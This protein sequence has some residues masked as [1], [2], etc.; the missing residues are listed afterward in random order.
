VSDYG[1]DDRAIGVPSRAE[2]KNFSSN[3]WVQTRSGFTQPPDQWV[4]EFLSPGVKRGRVVT[5]NTDRQ[6]V[7]WS[8]MSRSYTSFP[9]SV[10]MVSCE[11]ALYFYIQCVLSLWDII[12][13]FVKYF[14]LNNIIKIIINREHKRKQRA[15]YLLVCVPQ[16]CLK[17]QIQFTVSTALLCRSDLHAGSLIVIHPAGVALPT[18]QETGQITYSKLHHTS[19]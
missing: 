14:V 2:G 13:V 12:F 7:S 15:L 19:P 18:A 8:R 4:R 17:Q 5:L 3:I 11:T 6:V 9:S 10:V 1:L 16:D